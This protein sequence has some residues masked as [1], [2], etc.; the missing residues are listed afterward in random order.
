MRANPIV[1]PSPTLDEDLGFA[2]RVEDLAI[3]KLVAQ[4]RAYGP[5][6][7]IIADGGPLQRGGSDAQENPPPKRGISFDMQDRAGC[8]FPVREL[9][10]QGS[11]GVTGVGHHPRE[12][13]A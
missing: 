11:L 12:S 5:P 10:V 3:E 6:W 4:A 8:T 1:V 7:L 13:R 2:Q 9:A